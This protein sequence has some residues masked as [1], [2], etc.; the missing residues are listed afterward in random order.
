MAVTLAAL[1][2][3]TDIDENTQDLTSATVQSSATEQGCLEIDDNRQQEIRCSTQTAAQLSMIAAE[4]KCALK[5]Y[6]EVY[7]LRHAASP[8]YARHESQRNKLHRKTAPHKN[9]LKLRQ[10]LVLRLKALRATLQTAAVDAH[11]QRKKSVPYPSEMKGFNDK[12]GSYTDL[13]YEDL[14]EKSLV[15]V[16]FLDDMFN[17]IK[18]WVCKDTNRRYTETK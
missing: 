11:K 1:Y 9:T 6:S 13:L 8:V 15:M 3:L 17:A 4:L 14:A 12:Y 5:Q 16:V 18:C 10:D 2:G 7:D